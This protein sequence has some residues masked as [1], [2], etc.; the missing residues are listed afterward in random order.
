[1]LAMVAGMAW[2]GW[3]AGN[4][5]WMCGC[6]CSGRVD[7]TAVSGRI[8]RRRVSGGRTGIVG[9]SG[10]GEAVGRRVVAVVRRAHWVGFGMGRRLL[11]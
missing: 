8:R 9:G 5:N 10:G 1:M 3:V 7:V 11:E 6:E 4:T 2:D